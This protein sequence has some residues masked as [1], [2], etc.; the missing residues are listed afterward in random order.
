[1]VTQKTH[2]IKMLTLEKLKYEFKK[3]FQKGI[4][5]WATR[6]CFGIWP[7]G[8]RLPT[9]ALWWVKHFLVFLLHIIL[10][11]RNFDRLISIVTFMFGQYEFIFENNLNLLCS[12]I[13]VVNK[14]TTEFCL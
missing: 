9:T 7:A 4:N 13:C 3:L 10:V 1:M 8:C 11:S 12:T 14:S 2:A 5:L 6:I